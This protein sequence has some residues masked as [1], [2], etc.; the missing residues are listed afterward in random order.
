MRVNI[1]C[2][3][4]GASL[5]SPRNYISSFSEHPFNHHYGW[6]F[7]M[8]LAVACGL[9]EVYPRDLFLLQWNSDGP[10]RSTMIVYIVRL[11]EPYIRI[12]VHS[13]SA[14]LSH[15]ACCCAFTRR[16]QS[17]N[18]YRPRRD[19]LR[20]LS[21][22]YLTHSASLNLGCNCSQRFERRSLGQASLCRPGKVS[23]FSS[24]LDTQLT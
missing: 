19:I 24:V 22:Q 13:P 9:I 4:G 20:E 11:R 6:V 16:R 14:Y 7:F 5:A 23:N 2:K 18:M 12:V 17:Q 10:S 21:S 3:S 15:H 1:T 8:W